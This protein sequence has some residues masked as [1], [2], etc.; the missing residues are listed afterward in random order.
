MLSVL[1]IG[2]LGDGLSLLLSRI[3]GKHV[4]NWAVHLDE[5]S[6]QLVLACCYTEVGVLQAST[7]WLSPVDWLAALRRGKRRGCSCRNLRVVCVCSEDSGLKVWA[8]CIAWFTWLGC[9]GVVS[10]LPHRRSLADAGPR[11]KENLLLDLARCILNSVRLPCCGDAAY[12][13]STRETLLVWFV[14]P[15]VECVS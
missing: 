13:R 12:A 6:L 2:L 8:G 7:G 4:L 3:C 9:R 15:V 14:L 11:R 1:F 10:N 5:R